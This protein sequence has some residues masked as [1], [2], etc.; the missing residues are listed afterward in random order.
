MHI[1]SGVPTS[2]N[3]DLEGAVGVEHL[4]ALVAGVGHVDVALG[5]DGERLDAVEL[6]RLGAGG[7]PVLDEAAVLVEL[8]D[9]VVGADAVGDVDVAG[10]VPRHV[11]R[12]VEAGT[13]RALA[14][15]ERPAPPAP[16]R[17]ARAPG[18]APAPA[19]PP[20]AAGTWPGRTA[21]PPPAA[22]AAARRSFRACVRAPARRG[23]RCRTS[24]PGWR[25]RRWSR[26]CP[27]DRCAGRWRR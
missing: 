5:V 3:C 23:L 11:G 8:G 26:R 1:A 13:G 18:P 25:R 27:A 7:A 24:P 15:L 14:G 4:D 2:P 17:L 21:G 10:R 19:R 6:T 9:A 16:H 12:T 22:A 20:P